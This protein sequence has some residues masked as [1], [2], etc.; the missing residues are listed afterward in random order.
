MSKSKS[1]KKKPSVK[2]NDLQAT[3]DPKGGSVALHDL[4]FTHVVD[5]ASPI[6]IDSTPVKSK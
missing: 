1:S 6:L 2:V 5:K 3:K 4:S